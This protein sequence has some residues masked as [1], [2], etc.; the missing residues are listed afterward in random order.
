MSKA[1]GFKG[2]ECLECGAIRS[3]VSESGYTLDGQRIRLRRC[4]DC[5][6]RA[7]S[8]EVF[9]HPDETTFFRLNA[10]KVPERETSYRRDGKGVYRVPQRWVGPDHIRVRVLI[11]RSRREVA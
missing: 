3:K 10:R 8:I 11:R 1:W 7:T 6:Q 5:G 2:P 4:L 9:I